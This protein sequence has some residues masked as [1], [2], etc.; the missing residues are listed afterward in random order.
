MERQGKKVV[1]LGVRIFDERGEMGKAAA[2]DAAKRINAIIAEK[3][4]ANLVF[5]LLLRMMCWS[6]C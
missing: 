2:E 3:G 6:T 1:N 5:A 4:E